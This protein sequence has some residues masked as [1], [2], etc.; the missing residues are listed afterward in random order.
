MLWVIV[1]AGFAYFL[2]RDQLAQD[3][4]LLWRKN[5]LLAMFLALALISILWSIGPIF[6]LFRALELLF[7]TLIAAYLGMRLGPEQL[8][9][10][11]FWFGAGL[12]I[13]SIALVFGAPKTGTMYWAPF[14]GAW[15][16]VYWHRNHLASI[17][18][19]LS[20]VYLSRGLTAFQSRNSK[21]ILDLFFYLISLGILYFARSATGFIVFLV[22]NF[23]VVCIWLWLRVEHRMQ[24]RHY[25]M[26]LGGVILASVLVLLNLNFVFGLF[27]RDTTLTGRVG[28]WSHLLE[29]ASQH[30]WLGHGFGAAWMFDS[31]REQIRLLVGWASQPLIGDNGFLDIFLHLGIIGL[32]V[33]VGML[34]VA[35]AKSVSYG[36]IQKTLPGFFPLLVMVYAFIANITF[37]LFAETEV[38]VWLLIVT[39][40]FMST[41][42]LAHRSERTSRA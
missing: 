31:F 38:F 29:I 7:A 37:S 22:L 39:V 25:F 13:L 30:F 27:H 20:A 23:F 8:M 4:F 34:L 32:L 24:R 3:Y 41:S 1:T 26:L 15:R 12:F 9:E 16:G 36:L 14:D 19:L 40:L 6:T 28:L 5:W 10:T 17:T 18:A 35:T 11:L 21:G 42:G 2:F 33:F